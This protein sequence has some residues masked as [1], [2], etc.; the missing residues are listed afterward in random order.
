VLEAAFLLYVTRDLALTPALLGTV[1]AVGSAGFL[2]G[3][4]LAERLTRRLGVGP[5]LI[6]ALLTLGL[7]DLAVPLV[8]GAPA[9][10]TLVL[11]AAEFFFGLGLLVFNITAVS[12]RQSSTPD[13][14]L[15][16]M[17][18]SMRFL[19]FG[20]TPL[21]SLAGGLL[22]ESLGLRPTL[23]LAVAG[24][25]LAALWLLASPLR[26]VRQP[27]PPHHA[28]TLAVPPS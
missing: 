25:L 10:V 15:G 11:I 19:A 24:E 13:Y 28:T 18:A 20:L 1:F 17:N 3:A 14:L 8:G 21:G 2:V 16:R 6:L 27:P 12:L 4:L 26:T 23:I 7:A 5:T 9:V 22:G